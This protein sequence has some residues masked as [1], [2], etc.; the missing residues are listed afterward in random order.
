MMLGF[1]GLSL[2]V[3]DSLP[4]AEER[5]DYQ[6]TH[7]RQGKGDGESLLLSGVFD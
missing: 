7:K 5:M 4:T 1:T 6:E 2:C 3:V